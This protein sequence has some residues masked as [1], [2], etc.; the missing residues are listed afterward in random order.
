MK[1]VAQTKNI[2]SIIDLNPCFVCL[3]IVDE[4]RDNWILTKSNQSTI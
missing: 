1:K 3:K 4:M 2:Q